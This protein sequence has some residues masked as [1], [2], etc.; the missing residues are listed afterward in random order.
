MNTSLVDA[1]VQAVL[2]LS[3]EE[4]Q[5][6]GA[7]WAA[8]GEQSL[9]HKHTTHEP[10]TP[11]PFPDKRLDLD[12]EPFV[13]MWKDREDMADSTQWIRSRRQQEWQ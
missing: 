10:D 8:K 11:E 3:P 12:N 1:L 9:T 13:G 4:R 5:R 6:F 7:L 2:S